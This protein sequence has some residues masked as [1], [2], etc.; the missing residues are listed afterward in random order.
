MRGVLGKRTFRTAWDLKFDD[1]TVFVQSS[2]APLFCYVNSRTLI[3]NQVTM[4]ENTDTK[5][6]YEKTMTPAARRMKLE[7]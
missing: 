2:I 5:Q 7:H 4:W 6:K 3:T 1:T